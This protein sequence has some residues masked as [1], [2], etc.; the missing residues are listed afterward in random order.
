MARFVQS[1]NLGIAAMLAGGVAAAA[2]PE[3]PPA[4]PTL[5]EPAFAFDTDPSTRMTLPIVIGGRGP[6]AFLVDT[7][8]ERTILSS[9]LAAQ[10]ALVAGRRVNLVTVTGASQVGTVTV[11]NLDFG[12]KRRLKDFEA[13]LLGA[14]NIGAAGLLGIDSLQS[15]QVIFD[16]AAGTLS[17]TRPASRSRPTHAEGDEIVVTARKKLGRLIFAEASVERQSVQAILDTGA[18]LTIGNEALR[19]RL[20]KQGKLGP[21]RPVQIMSVSGE[22]LTLDCATVRDFQI[23]NVRM[24]NIRVAFADLEPFKRLK[25]DDKPALL[26]GMDTLK[27]FDRVAVDFANRRVRFISPDLSSSR[28]EPQMAARERRPAAS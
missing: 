6:Y 3:L 16:F 19:R 10:L 12:Q 28:S 20:I 27:L 1:A 5:A 4:A 25:L 13:P 11:P 2:V 7:G 14:G 18:Q 26:L 8:S 9:E 24:K 17:L 23:G 22:L 21:L 15:Q